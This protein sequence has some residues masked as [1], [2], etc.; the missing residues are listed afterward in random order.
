MKKIMIKKK[1][2]K[3]QQQKPK[4]KKSVPTPDFFPIK[5]VALVW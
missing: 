5:F 1:N 2:H 4:F 3:M